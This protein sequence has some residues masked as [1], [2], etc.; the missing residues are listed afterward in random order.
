MTLLEILE[1]KGYR[2]DKHTVHRYIQEF[3]DEEF[4][5][6]KDLDKPINLLEIGVLHGESMKLWRD[7]FG[8]E[9]LMVGLDIYK[10]VPFNQVENNLQEFN[11]KLHLV[12]S[13][14]E[15]SGARQSRVKFL[16]EYEDLGFDIIIDDGLHTEESQ[17]KTFHN[18]KGLMND[19]GLYV[20][21]DV[22]KTS[23]KKLSEIENIEILELNDGPKSPVKKQHIAIIKF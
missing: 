4:Q 6:Y 8:P 21:E 14:Q 9:S 19:G 15:D 3:Y 10:R 12:D 1:Q 17:F 18:F 16:E 7:Y 11:V 23:I 2:T 22:R 20:I 13:F 5:K